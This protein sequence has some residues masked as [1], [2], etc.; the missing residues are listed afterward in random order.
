MY[1]QSLVGQVSNCNSK[2]ALCRPLRLVVDLH[3]SE[4]AKEYTEEHRNVRSEI[5]RCP[6]DTLLTQWDRATRRTFLSATRSEG[7]CKSCMGLM[8]DKSSTSIV[9]TI[10]LDTRTRPVDASTVL[11]P[12]VKFIGTLDPMWLSP[13]RTI[14]ERLVEDTLVRRYEVEQT[15]VDGLPDGEGSFTACSFWCV[16]C[17]AAWTV[18]VNSR[19]RSYCL[20]SFWAMLITLD[21]IQS[22]L[23]QTDNILASS[24]RHSHIW[25]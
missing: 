19:K 14:E 7:R 15:D 24:R 25:L 22:S 11:M 4:R 3:R 18:K 21:C 1:T 2:A 12:M 16:E 9:W 20:K 8:E 13:M 10:S 6:V 23:A 17:L 5:L